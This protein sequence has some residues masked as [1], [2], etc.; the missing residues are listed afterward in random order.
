MRGGSAGKTTFL[1]VLLV[2]TLVFA[3]TAAAALRIFAGA[4]G[5]AARA[6][7]T[8]RAVYEAT[9]AAER[10]RLHADNREALEAALGGTWSGNTLEAVTETGLTLRLE[11]R[12]DDD[13]LAAGHG[14]IQ[15]A[16]IRILRGETLLF[17]LECAANRGEGA[18]Q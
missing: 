11:L 16:E 13:E 18:A 14:R 12:Q 7:D 3:L 10:F 8:R 6:D 4:A 17:A 15:N 9:Q 2:C 1:A 5:M